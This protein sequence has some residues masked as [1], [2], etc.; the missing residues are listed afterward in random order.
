MTVT[1]LRR[2]GALVATLALAS[3][4]LAVTATSATAATPRG[5]LVG[6]VTQPGGGVVPGAFVR[7]FQENNPAIE[8][9][10]YINVVETQPNG[11]YKLAAPAGTYDLSVVDPCDVY[12]DL[13]ASAI[14]VT[15]NVE[16]VVNAAFTTAESPAPTDLCDRVSPEVSGLAKV[17]VPL[18]LTTPGVY[19]QPGVSLSYQWF[20]ADDA[21]PGATGLSYTPTAND[22]ANYVYVQITAAKAGFSTTNF[23]AGPEEPVVSGDYSFKTAPKVVGL[24]ILGKTISASRGSVAP[25]ANVT[26]QWFR[27]GK[28]IAGQTARTHRVAKADYQK[29]LS[30]VITYKSYGYDPIVRT[31]KA[32]FDAKKKAKASAKVSTGK[33]SATFTIKV[34]PSASNKAKGKVSIIENGKTLKRVSIKSGTVK[35][36]LS[37]LKSGK[38]SFK[39]VY[40]G[41]KYAAGTSKTVRVKK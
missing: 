1:S 30:A 11:T 8:T 13:P 35:V 39:V 24:P 16:T 27:D 2:T 20:S 29:K 23:Y 5:I 33:K 38:H 21:V 17:G 26:Y 36:K 6:T 9:D 40:Q 37:N 4:T 14:A 19:T 25:G 28:A 10:D 32:P 34:S 12:E 41:K 22:I 7:V 3:S 31:V 18:T 15:A